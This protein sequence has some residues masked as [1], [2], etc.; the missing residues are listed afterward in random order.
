MDASQ[1]VL[2]NPLLYLVVERRDI[3]LGFRLRDFLIKYGKL[4]LSNL[5]TVKDLEE[6]K[7]TFSLGTRNL[8]E[9]LLDNCYCAIR[10]KYK[11]KIKV[12]IRVL[13]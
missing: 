10:Q 9:K 8:K 2:K 13:E 1:K 3:R 11:I 12:S 5:E 6:N 4:G 7:N